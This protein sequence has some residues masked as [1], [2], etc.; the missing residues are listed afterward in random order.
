[1]MFMF[2]F[3]FNTDVI[4][5][6]LKGT[7]L[8]I[9]VLSNDSNT[10]ATSISISVESDDERKILAEIIDILLELVGD[11]AGTV[12]KD[13]HGKKGKVKESGDK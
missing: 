8:I 9:R 7:P 12:I 11:Y 2:I 4:P 3:N 5:H 10:E 13:V 6:S 1:M